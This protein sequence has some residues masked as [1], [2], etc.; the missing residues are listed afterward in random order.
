LKIEGFAL[1]L[2]TG[3]TQ[4]SEQGMLRVGTTVGTERIA[5]AAWNTPIERIEPVGVSKIKQAHVGA[6]SAVSSGWV[7]GGS[8]FSSIAAG[9]LLGL[10]LDAW[11][12]TAPWFVVIGIVL[13]SISGFYRMWDHM[14]TPLGKQDLFS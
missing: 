13:G 4:R 12:N 7:E 6:T 14:R 9:T 8:L 3:E 1:T 5:R 2:V 10:G 11:I